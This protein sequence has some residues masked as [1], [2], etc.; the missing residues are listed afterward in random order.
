M[1]LL[2]T[3]TLT[4]A[5]L[6][7]VPHLARETVRISLF[8]LF[9]PETIHLRLASGESASLDAPGLTNSRSI[10]RGDLVVI[11][12]S[13]NRLN[14]MVGGPLAGGLSQ[15]FPANEVRITPASS[16]TLELVLPGRIKRE[17]RG[18]VSIDAG[19]GGRGPLRIV[20][21]TDRESAVASVVAAE[22]SRRETE[23]L[24]A[25][26][27]VV[28]SYMRSHVGRHAS[29]GFDFCDTTHC[30]LFRGEQDL[31]DRIASPAVV[32]A[33]AGTAGQI[34]RFEGRP[35]EVYYS[36]ACGGVSATPLMVWGGSSTYPYTR[37]VC[38][39]CHTSRFDRWERS[40]SASDVLAALSSFVA[41]TLTKGTEIIT[42]CEHPSGFVRS[43]TLH[44]GARK[45][46]LTADAFRRAIGLRLG[47]NTVL[48][49]TFT[50]ERRGSKFLFRGRGFGSQVGLCEAGAVVQAAAGRS[51]REILS[52][53]YPGAVVSEQDANE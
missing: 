16:A 12:L 41:S 33:V 43:V 28:R 11:R 4:L 18:E 37:I 24:K 22:T 8:T 51:Y 27:V 23:A 19:P 53:Y 21:V 10:V 46:A 36:A 38:R 14:I 48:S 3:L 44:D 26:G 50:V 30:Q 5:S 35:V 25:L 39:W 29:E 31:N 9:K 34:L 7:A 47:W 52:Y 1:N 45:I 13:G 40:A 32:S 49:P 15:P 20:L 17:V 6:A 42:D 2:A